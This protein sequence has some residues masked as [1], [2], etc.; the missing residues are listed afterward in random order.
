MAVLKF[1]LTP[2]E[3][4]RIDHDDLGNKLLLKHPQHVDGI[5]SRGAPNGITAMEI[6][7]SS[8]ERMRDWVRE[9]AAKHGITAIELPSEGIPDHERLGYS[10]PSQKEIEGMLVNRGVQS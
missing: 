4:M 6:A 5:C 10:G 9:L 2:P 1:E 8:P 7:T 3:G